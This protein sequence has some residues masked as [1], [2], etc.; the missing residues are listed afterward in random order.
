MLQY[1]ANSDTIM[2]ATDK[3]NIQGSVRCIFWRLH[4]PMTT[5]NIPALETTPAIPLFAQREGMVLDWKM[6]V[7]FLESK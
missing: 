7:D 4:I 5:G 6:V 2:V 3:K 1:N